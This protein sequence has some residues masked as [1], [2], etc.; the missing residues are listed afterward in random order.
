MSL[1]ASLGEANL[2]L[3]VKEVTPDLSIA[4]VH[5]TLW[6]WYTVYGLLL[7][8]ASLVAQLVKNPPAMQE[9]S[10]RFLG[11]EDPLENG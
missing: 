1:C 10:V 3:W 8:W 9:T 7:L 6:N 4:K 5:F 11:R 2:E